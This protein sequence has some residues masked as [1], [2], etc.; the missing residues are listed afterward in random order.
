MRVFALTLL[1]AGC[2][3]D[4][5]GDAAGTDTD[6][7]DGGT[8]GGGPVDPCA[9]VPSYDLDNMSCDQLATAF[10]S[11]ISA[12]DGCT[13][14]SDCEVFYPDCAEWN[15]VGCWYTANDCATDQLDELIAKAAGLICASTQQC[16]GCGG[17]P[18]VDCVA[19]KC[20]LQY[21]TGY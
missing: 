11:T 7:D 15:Q 8:D 19:G 5:D 14:K 21:G 6:T 4:G 16:S 9:S 18:A 12:A 10:E 20:E 13:A 1:V 3:G 2:G 17:A